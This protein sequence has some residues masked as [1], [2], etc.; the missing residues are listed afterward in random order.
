[1]KKVVMRV[2]GVAHDMD[3]ELLAAGGVIARRVDRGEEVN[4]CFVAYLIYGHKGKKF[5]FS[6]SWRRRENI[7]RVTWC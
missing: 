3:D 7:G 6:T 5:P 1:M 4:T 2:H